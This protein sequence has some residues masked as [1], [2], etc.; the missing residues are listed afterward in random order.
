MRAPSDSGT[1]ALSDM[2]AFSP[3]NMTWEF[4]APA[5]IYT[6]DLSTRSSSNYKVLSTPPELLLS[7]YIRPCCVLRA[8]EGPM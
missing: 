3:A 4:V 5:V 1:G 8:R 2:W 7:Y 6:T